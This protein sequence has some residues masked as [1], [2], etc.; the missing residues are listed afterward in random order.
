VPGVA[1]LQLGQLLDVSVDR[2]G[3][4]PQQPGPV[5]RRGVPP[6][7]EGTRRSLDRLVGALQVGHRDG[8][9]DLLG[10]RVDD[11]VQDGHGA[12]SSRW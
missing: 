9:D 5:R 8:R 12:T 1:H 4:P 6:R 11:V 3:E 2:L 10:G 7:R